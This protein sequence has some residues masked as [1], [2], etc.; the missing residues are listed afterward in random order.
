MSRG[1]VAVGGQKVRRTS[2]RSPFIG[3]PTPVSST[4]SP[5]PVPDRNGRSNVNTGAAKGYVDY[6]TFHQMAGELK[7]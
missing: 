1:V 7:A 2:S 4:G 5:R 3:S 6:K